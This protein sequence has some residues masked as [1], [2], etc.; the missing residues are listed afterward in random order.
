MRISPSAAAK[1]AL[2]I[3]FWISLMGGGWRQQGLHMFLQNLCCYKHGEQTWGRVCIGRNLSDFGVP[4]T[5]ATSLSLK[6]MY[7][8]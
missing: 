3:Q 2:I 8:D 4:W 6:A 7:S 5:A 1:M